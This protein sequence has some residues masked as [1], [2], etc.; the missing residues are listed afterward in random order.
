MCVCIQIYTYIFK[1]MPQNS[2]EQEEMDLPADRVE[3]VQNVLNAMQKILECP[4]W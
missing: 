4:I 1:L 3:E 2:V